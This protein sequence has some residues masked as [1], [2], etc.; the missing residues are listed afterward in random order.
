MTTNLAPLAK[1]IKSSLYKVNGQVARYI[2]ESGPIVEGTSYKF[3]AH[4]EQLEGLA[5]NIDRATKEEYN[6]YLGK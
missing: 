5:G 2:G 4:A 3:R 6:A 1:L